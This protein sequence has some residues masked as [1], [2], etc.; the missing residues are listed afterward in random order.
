[1]DLI[2][3]D[4]IGPF[5]GRLAMARKPRLAITLGRLM[6]GM[7]GI[8]LVGCTTQNTYPESE[9][10]T[11]PVPQQT[12]GEQVGHEPR[13]LVPKEGWQEV[14]RWSGAGI[15]KTEPFE[16]TSQ[17][18]WRLVWNI[19]PNFGLLNIYVKDENGKIVGEASNTEHIRQDF[20]YQDFSTGSGTFSLVI[21]SGEN[22]EWEVMVE[23]P[24]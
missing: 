23:E 4:R 16:I 2:S 19:G 20:N 1:M 8:V 17:V 3:N 9:H 12:N 15:Q 13:K 10:V 24:K 14:A 22:L 11:M 6:I 21:S 7:A 5:E 18:A